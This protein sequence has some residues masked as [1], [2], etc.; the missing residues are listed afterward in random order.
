[1]PRALEL[2]LWLMYSKSMVLKNY[3]DRIHSGT[4]GRGP[5]GRDSEQLQHTV[6]DN[7]GRDR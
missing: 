4:Y 6:K 2:F 7:F 3:R 5:A 1:M